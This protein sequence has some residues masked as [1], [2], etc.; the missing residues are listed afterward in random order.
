MYVSFYENGD[1]VLYYRYG[2]TTVVIN[3]TSDG[4][5]SSL[6]LHICDIENLC[7]HTWV[8]YRLVGN[9]LLMQI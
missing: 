4:F 2:D 9:F 6:V 5:T 1:N 7:T 3:Q 8:P